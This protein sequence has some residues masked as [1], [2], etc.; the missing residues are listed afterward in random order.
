MEENDYTFVYSSYAYLKNERKHVAKIPKSMTYKELL[1]NHAIHTSTVMINM[2]KIEKEDIYM[3]NIKRGQDMATWWKILKS[4]ITA[5]GITEV[6]SIYR[7][8]EKS[9]SSNKIRAIMRTW[10]LFKR[11]DLSFIQR[12]YYF[13]CYGF[14][15]AKR[16]IA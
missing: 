12:V 15:A 10:K 1:K 8:G 13:S 7:V 5:Y 16:R 11:E 6:L 9:L 14:N 2:E 3:P 4:G